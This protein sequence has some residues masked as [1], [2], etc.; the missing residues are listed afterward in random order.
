MIYYKKSKIFIISIIIIFLFNVFVSS[1]NITTTDKGDFNSS[2]GSIS[3]ND[4]KNKNVPVNNAS[5][6]SGSNNSNNSS[7]NNGK[8]NGSNSNNN[9]NNK[10][11]NSNKDVSSNSSTG[12]NGS[13]SSNSSNG[14]K[15]ISSSNTTNNASGVNS[16][17]VTPVFAALSDYLSSIKF[18]FL[19]PQNGTVINQNSVMNIKWQCDETLVDNNRSIFFILQSL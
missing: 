9:S 10:T 8:S 4:D 15:G 13:N 3:K 1:Q 18:M 5:G 2:N 12:N 14:T 17:R 6:S 16:T 19:E 11:K 7:S